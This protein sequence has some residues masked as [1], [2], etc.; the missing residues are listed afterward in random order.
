MCMILN[1]EAEESHKAFIN[2]CFATFCRKLI[3]EV[4]YI[5]LGY[6]SFLKFFNSHSLK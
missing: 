4:Y 3:L 6:Q 1:L 5:Y 2:F